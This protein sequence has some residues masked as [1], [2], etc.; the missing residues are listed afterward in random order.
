MTK[1]DVRK[2]A[3]ARLKSGKYE[4][5]T[6]PRA[7]KE[8]LIHELEIHEAELAMQMEELERAREASEAASRRY[9]DLFD[10]APVP[11]VTLDRSGRIKEAN[12]AAADLLGI[13]RAVLLDRPLSAFMRTTDAD[14]FHVV[15]Q[16][17]LR[18]GAKH[19]CELSLRCRNGEFRA[20]HVALTWPSNNAAG[21]CRCALIDLTALRTAEEAR[22]TAESNAQAIVDAAPDAIITM[23]GDASIV[24]V[25]AAAERTFGWSRE[26]MVGESFHAIV[27][28]V[29]E[30]GGADATGRPF[31]LRVGR[32]GR[33]F[34]GVRKD[35]TS[36]PV[37]LDVAEWRA[38]GERMLT[39]ICR[40][41]GD[42]ER[43]LA[44]L[45]ETQERFALITDHIEDVFY[46]VEADEKLSY[47][48]PAFER[49]WEASA[50]ALRDQ[51]DAW[52]PAVHEEDQEEVDGARAALRRGDPFDIEYRVVRADGAVRW[53]H[54][55]AFPIEDERGRVVRVVGVARDQ[56]TERELEMELRQHQKLDTIGAL[57]SGIAHDL[58]NVLQVVVG[59]VSIACDDRTPWEHARQCLER[60]RA[61]A[62]RGGDLVHRITGF[63]RKGPT[64]SFPLPFDESLRE[65]LALLRPLL[66][67]HIEVVEQLHSPG[68]FVHASQVQLDQILLNLGSNSRDAMPGGGT[69]TIRSERVA[70]GDG[71]RVRLTF[72]DTGCGMDEETKARMLEIFFTTKKPGRGTGLGLATVR[73]VA[74]HLGGALQVES[75]KGAG[76]VVTIELPTCAPK[77]G[78]PSREPGG[79]RF[80]GTVLVA[81][82]DPLVRKTLRR[83]LE[84][85]GFRALEL[86]T[87]R[88]ALEVCRRAAETPVLL[89]SDVLMP[90]MTGLELAASLRTRMPALPVLFVS[91]ETLDRSLLPED[92]RCLAKP[93][94]RADLVAELRVLLP[95]GKRERRGAAAPESGRA[96]AKAMTVL[97]V[98]GDPDRRGALLASLRSRY[99]RVLAAA[100]AADA[101]T[102]ASSWALDAV[103]ACER[104]S[105]HLAAEVDRAQP[106]VPVVF[107]SEGPP[108]P[109]G[110]T[111]TC[112]AADAEA[113]FALVERAAQSG[114]ALPA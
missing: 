92:M 113:L 6:P 59:A 46:I 14:S 35:G 38:R 112:D 50:A 13:E 1:R 34:T 74:E 16:Q 58:S 26:E 57:S 33:P 7:S 67:E 45:E 52:P 104:L 10:Q 99:A 8:Q 111:P 41:V 20:T 66:G 28:P 103:V 89:V 31:A 19:G 61:V 21:D 30:A 2:E 79:D 80:E 77:L 69:I 114:G 11:F 3:E 73:A 105:E 87:G 62:L 15:R 47:V 109:R 75:E 96:P 101:L 98:D 17:A 55:R 82:D 70:G 53:I 18:S 100:S 60:A 65:A 48:S 29:G 25:N 9:A 36:F 107:V 110:D 88:D 86:E 85:L 5:C 63:A 64:K 72:G 27:R 93:F 37:E 108:Q 43:A 54:D 90:H 4:R 106:G 51:A 91:G 22:R 44:R 97:V 95:G 81:E 83:E 71:P 49:V 102:L 68:C 32:A 56:T 76:T 24:S 42:R 12:F 23:D 94:D 84:R 39:A 40:D 78:E